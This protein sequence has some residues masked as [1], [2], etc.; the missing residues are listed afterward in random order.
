M[1]SSPVGR[2]ERERD[3][4]FGRAGRNVRFQD[5]TFVCSGS[6]RP[7]GNSE[8]S[9]EVNTKLLD[10]A[11]WYGR[12]EHDSRPFCNTICSPSRVELA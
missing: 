12:R 2:G 5:G 10:F 6:Q 1:Y 8:G 9:E 3:R 11:V 7:R 4:D